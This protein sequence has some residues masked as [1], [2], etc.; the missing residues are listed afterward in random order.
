MLTMMIN[1]FNVFKYGLTG[2]FLFL[3]ALTYWLVSTLFSLYEELAA[4][5]FITQGD[6]QQ[7]VARF[8]AIIGVVMLF[9]LTY[10]LLKSL[11]NPDE[12]N[13]NVGKVATNFVISLVL[14]GV[15]PVLFNYAFELQ[16]AIIEDSVISTLVL[17]S[18]NASV[19]NAGT[20][21][22]FMI[23]N[24]FVNPEHANIEGESGEN[25]Q[26][27]QDSFQGT[28]NGE[29]FLELTDF[30]EAIHEGESGVT[31]KPIISTA[32][33]LFMVYILVSFCIDLGIRVFKLAFYQ[34]IAPI[35]ILMRVMPEKKSVFDNWVKGTIATYLE[36]FIRLFVMFVIILLVQ[37]VLA[38]VTFSKTGFLGNVILI[39]GLFAFA[40]QA[41]KLI[42]NVIG[43]DSANI[44]LGIGGKLASSG[45]FGVG[46]VVGGGLTSGVQGLFS[47]FG[48]AGM[49][50][51][52]FRNAN[53]FK[54]KATAL[55]GA[56]SSSLAIP[57]GAVGSMARGGYNAGKS[58][59]GSKNYTEMAKA[60]S[61]AATKEADRREKRETFK[62]TY[63]SGPKGL[64]TGVATGVTTGIK[65]WATGSGTG[66]LNKV[67]K[68]E[69]LKQLFS[70]YS[71]IYETGQY[72]ALNSQLQQLKALKAQGARVTAEGTNI[73]TAI[74]S[75]NTKLLESRLDSIR[76]N[77][78][79]T[80]YAISN[81][82]NFGKANPNLV[83]EFLKGTG[84]DPTRLNDLIIKGGKVLDKNTSLEVTPEKLYSMIEGAALNN[85]TYDKSSKKY[86]DSVSKMATDLDAI[87]KAQDA[88][89]DALKTYSKK[90]SDSIRNDKMSVAYKEAQKRQEASKK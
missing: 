77:T 27:F 5:R 58:G 61:V 22:S 70:D 30:A 78:Q 10:G 53:G 50:F 86:I 83:S 45:V 63:G 11:V 89:K 88:N 69:E 73:D 26:D 18:E 40:K 67:K 55:G 56:L 71:S 17:G 42:S 14:L 65:S 57:F 76:N 59:I 4:V 68:S 20:E 49:A 8:S 3:D 47:G 29:K 41:P 28:G 66:I 31:Y 2:L 24:T 43:V 72:K 19:S 1:I 12:L 34:I 16:D 39:L 54:N 46:A 9:Y 52:R 84:I 87:V 15:T 60:A 21:A 6:Y 33:G 48:N 64:V 38:H 80:A 23:L 79:A 51:N 37:F 62:A 85:V 82:S 25:W 7:I 75:L 74:E 36:V 44:K 32:C 35:P 81:I 13:K 90:V